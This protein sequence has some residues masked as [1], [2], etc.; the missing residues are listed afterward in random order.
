MDPHFH[1]WVHLAAQEN[2]EVWWSSTEGGA[3]KGELK[4]VKSAI[5]KCLLALVSGPWEQ[6]EPMWWQ[7]LL[8]NV[9]NVYH[10]SSRAP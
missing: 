7:L 10:H 3:G 8:F 5:L 4:M 2:P 6:K 1:I 9:H